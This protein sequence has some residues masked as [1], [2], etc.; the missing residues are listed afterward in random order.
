MLSAR[1]SSKGPDNGVSVMKNLKTRW[2]I[3]GSAI[4]LA[5]TLGATL[6]SAQQYPNRTITVIIP[7][8]GGSAS[9]VV[10]RIM[11]NKMSANMG[12]RL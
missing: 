6:A 5:A 9:D 10:S 2:L 7:F 12:S 3:L 8:A 11:F 1:Q 4:A